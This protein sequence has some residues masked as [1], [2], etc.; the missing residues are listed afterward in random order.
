MRGWLS[1]W[2]AIWEPLHHGIWGCAHIWCVHFPIPVEVAR[3]ESDPPFSNGIFLDAILRTTQNH[4]DSVDGEFCT[5]GLFRSQPCHGWGRGS[6][7]LRPLQI[8]VK[9]QSISRLLARGAVVDSFP[10]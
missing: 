7:S 5:I 8:Q 2:G 4:G 3:I 6:E 10:G 9:N 1:S